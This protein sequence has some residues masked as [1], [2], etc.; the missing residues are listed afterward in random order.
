M[1]PCPC[2]GSLSIDST[3]HSEHTKLLIA[4]DVGGPF[5]IVC[6]S[7]HRYRVLYGI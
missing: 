7:L 1:T 2:H 3:A 5:L 4:H 6:S